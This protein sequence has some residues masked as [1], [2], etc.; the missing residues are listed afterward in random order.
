M[1]M[2]MVVAV[3]VVPSRGND[4]L[5]VVVSGLWFAPETHFGLVC[6]ALNDP[7]SNEAWISRRAMELCGL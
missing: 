6:F 1:V 3:V 4:F 5:L 2:V 7:R